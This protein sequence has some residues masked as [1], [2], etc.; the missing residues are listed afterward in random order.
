MTLPRK[1]GRSPHAA[2]SRGLDDPAETLHRRQSL[3][4]KPFLQAV[5]LSWYRRILP[6]LPP[7]GSRRVLELGSGAGFLEKALPGVITSDV[8]L[9]PDVDLIA[10]GEALPFA[11][12][13]LDG[14]ILVDVF[15]HIPMPRRF[16]SEAAR[17]LRT[18]GVLAM[19]EPWRTPW[20]S[21]IY[22]FFHPEPFDPGARNWEF[23][24]TGP[25]SGA[26]G[27]LPW[28]VFE[29]DRA[30][31]E[32]EFPG[33]RVASVQ[34]HTPFLYLLSGGFSLPAL[35][36]NFSFRFWQ[37]VEESIRPAVR[38]WAMFAMITITRK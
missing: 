13:S 29:R 37:S 1:T 14:I 21:F 34:L 31:F 5:Y 20:S 30:I 38:F 27:A 24:S 26:N 22:R 7:G 32:R 3:S 11:S 16:L 10:R 6:V 12:G 9:L 28:I 36:P 25:L 15:H 19:I 23:P 4:R 35:V 8:L 33:L 2:S 17:G 18:G